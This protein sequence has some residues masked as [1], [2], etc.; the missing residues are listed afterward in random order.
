MKKLPVYGEE[1]IDFL[2]VGGEGV[3]TASMNLTEKP[4]IVYPC[5]RNR[6]FLNTWWR[7]LQEHIYITTVVFNTE[8]IYIYLYEKKF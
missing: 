3:D 5:S 6:F 8:N 7:S 2:H 1:D 4:V